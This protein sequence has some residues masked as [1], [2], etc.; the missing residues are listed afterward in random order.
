MNIALL[1]YSG[2]PGIGG[3][4]AT[5]AAHA[6]LLAGDGYGVRIVAGKGEAS[7]AGVEMRAIA[8]LGS[9][10]ERIEA[11]QAELARGEVTPAF[12]ALVDE[13]TLLLDAALDGCAVA[14]V[15]NVHTLHKNL[16]FTAALER[17]HRQGRAPEMLAWAHDFAFTDPLY[18]PEMH[19]GWP[20]DLL[21][22]PWT[23]VRYVC[24][25]RDRRAVLAE[26]FAVPEQSI[27]VVTP[28]VDVERLL[29]LEPETAALVAQYD[30][31]ASAPLLVLPARLT[32]RK[33]I[34][35]ALQI[36]AALREHMPAPLLVIT[37]PPGPHNPGNA[38]YVAQLQTLR[39]E[40]AAPA[41]FLY[42]A[43][44]RPDATPRPISDAMIA[45]W[46]G[47]ADGLLF[48]SRAEGFG[49]PVIEAALR[50]VTV[51]CADIPPFREIVGDRALRFGLDEP[52]AEVARRIADALEHDPR[53]ALRR[54]ARTDIPGRRSI[55]RR[56]NRC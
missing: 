23:G 55:A 29:K 6:R 10:D 28:G 22:T 44:R 15:H 56:S 47:L 20:W 36:V 17:L 2:P 37:G 1:H 12:E 42:E 35:L 18:R 19:A 46:F 16:V 40:L 27:T 34:E 11:V 51:F 30:M 53:Y 49:M 41:L 21:R 45:D 24:V 3:V 33:N 14:I 52:P 54:Q 43:F 50:G 5:M 39:A 38:A 26:L 48:P 7:E 31:L 9:R 4:E 13:A 8:L 25:S 32:R